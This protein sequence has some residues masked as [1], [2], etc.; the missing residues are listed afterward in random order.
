MSALDILDLG[1]IPYAEAWDLQKRLVSERAAQARPDTLILAEHPPVYTRGTSARQAPALPLPHPVH[2][3]E[4]GG[5]VTFHGPGQLVGY[6]ILDLRERGL[7]VG[8]YLRLLESALISALAALGVPG[9]RAWPGRT[10]VWV[11]E[12]K[13]AS[14]GVAVRGWVSYHGFALCVRGDLKPFAAVRPCGFSSEVMTT[15]GALAGRD[16]SL[17]EAR[18]AVTEALRSALEPVRA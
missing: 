8:A 10:G 17:A 2:D 6:P 12:R 13:V 15:A 14:I 11:G 5:D 18:T 7:L 1:E 9:G 4:R 16:V 3:V